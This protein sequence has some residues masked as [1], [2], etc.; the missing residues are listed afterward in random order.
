MAEPKRLRLRPC[1]SLEDV[2]IAAGAALP[3]YFDDLCDVLSL[4]T[5]LVPDVSG[6]GVA[7]FTAMEPIWSAL[8]HAPLMA[9]DKV[10]RALPDSALAHWPAYAAAIRA[11]AAGSPTALRE[12]FCCTCDALALALREEEASVL[13][14]CI[15]NTDDASEATRDAAGALMASAVAVRDRM[16]YAEFLPTSCYIGSG[17][18]R[19]TALE[20]VLS[21]A[22][23]HR[24]DPPTYLIEE[25]DLESL[26]SL[27]F[28]LEAMLGSRVGAARGVEDVPPCPRDDRTLIDWIVEDAVETKWVLAKHGPLHSRLMESY[29]VRENAYDTAA[30]FAYA[31]RVVKLVVAAQFIRGLP[32]FIEHGVD[33][34]KTTPGGSDIPASLLRDLQAYAEH[35]KVPEYRGVDSLG[36]AKWWPGEHNIQMGAASDDEGEDEEGSSGDDEDEDDDDDDE[37]D[38]DIDEDLGGGGGHGGG[39]F[40]RSCGFRH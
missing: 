5:V 3:P 40:C 18:G 9:D 7:D 17:S 19:S 12:L 26:D 20:M 8:L 25:Y 13:N 27:N 30:E 33:A 14:G 10:H 11:S 21:D 15:F 38:D 32:G 23:F 37:D 24:T 36:L 35:A 28:C 39:R 29:N 31:H 1:A 2:V 22:G 16:I 6:G 34:V 4:E